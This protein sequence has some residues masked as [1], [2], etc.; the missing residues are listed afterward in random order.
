MAPAHGDIL[1]NVSKLA[2]KEFGRLGF[3]LFEKPA[4]Q[5]FTHNTRGELVRRPDIDHNQRELAD[6]ALA[7]THCSNSY[8]LKQ[9]LKASSNGSSLVYSSGCKV[10]FAVKFEGATAELVGIAVVVNLKEDVM[11]QRHVTALNNANVRLPL[12]G[13]FIELV[14]AKPK[15]GAATFLLLSLLNKLAKQFDAIACNP[16][17]E[18]ARLLFARHGYTNMVPGRNDLAILHRSTAVGHKNAYLDMLPGYAVT[19]RLCNRGGVRDKLKTYWE[20]GR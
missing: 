16:T 5:L 4:R 14:C 9:S 12:N 7:F 8:N 11:E 1:K 2:T 3:Q 13:L 19:M 17:H 15:S 6:M 10:L 18:R 20:C